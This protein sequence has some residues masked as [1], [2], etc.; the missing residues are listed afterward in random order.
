M[1]VKK[2]TRESIRVGETNLILKTDLKMHTLPDFIFK[3]RFELKNYI[4]TNPDFLT[5]FEPVLVGTEYD[6]TLNKNGSDSDEPP[7][8]VRLMDR[9]ARK[10]EVGPMAAVAGTIS[11]LSMG[12]LIENGAKYVIVDNGGDV[13]LKTNQDVVVGLYAGESSLSGAL[14]FKIKFG[15][16]PMGICTSSGTVGHS[17]SFGRADSLTVFANEASIADALAT[18]IANNAVGKKDHDAVQKALERA[19]DFRKSIQGVLVVV[20]ESA[21]TIGKI[22]KL[23]Q[24]DK[25]VV[26]GDIFEI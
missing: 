18:S 25:K 24:T 12:F 20:G 11:Q 3:I 22:P 26:L 17:I 23:V 4:R 21:G 16:T 15:K 10:A 7:L 9:A 1:T 2:I 5:S 14:G 8:I 19:D 13:A 6:E